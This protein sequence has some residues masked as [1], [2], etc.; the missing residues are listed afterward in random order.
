LI[1]KEKDGAF[2]LVRGGD[3]IVA[4]HYDVLGIPRGATLDDIKNAYHKISRDCHPNSLKFQALEKDEKKV[5]EE[6][7]KRVSNAYNILSDDAKRARYDN[8]EFSREVREES[9]Q[10]KQLDEARESSDFIRIFQSAPRG[11]EFEWGSAILEKSNAVLSTDDDFRD[12]LLV[13]ADNPPLDR[14]WEAQQ[15][16][17][18]YASRFHNKNKLSYVHASLAKRPPIGREEEAQLAR[19]AEAA[20]N[21]N[22][23]LF[24]GYEP[25]RVLAAIAQHSPSG[26]EA[27]FR[28][29]IF[30][31]V[32][33]FD[34]LF[35]NS[36]NS[37]AKRRYIDTNT[38]FAL[39]GLAK[40][41]L[42][43]K[44]WESQVEILNISR[45]I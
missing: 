19:V 21:Q 5:L 4:T 26:K 15:V 22:Y 41:P 2:S 33:N 35:E 17:L 11:E 34:K 1:R 6:K 25:G 45:T 24:G 30:D 44:E 3:L 8:E 18:H 32:N 9:A 37:Y 29:L 28:R 31:A 42:Q 16:I 27:K 40:A 43:G 23:P 38:S 36:Y 20:D 39:Q 12:V 10:Q 14:H 7:F 13:I